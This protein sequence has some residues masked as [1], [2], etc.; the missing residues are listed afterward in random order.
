[1]HSW[2]YIGAGDS[3][4]SRQLALIAALNVPVIMLKLGGRAIK[5]GGRKDSRTSTDLSRCSY[6]S[7]TGF[8]KVTVAGS[9]LR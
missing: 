3:Y 5:P 6:Q 8:S 9:R 1:M 7:L 4:L 2:W